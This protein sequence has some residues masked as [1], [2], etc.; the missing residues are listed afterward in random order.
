MKLERVGL[1]DCHSW[2]RALQSYEG[3]CGT[4]TREPIN[5][6]GCD[7]WGRIPI[8]RWQVIAIWDA[9]SIGREGPT[10]RWHQ[11]LNHETFRLDVRSYKFREGFFRRHWLTRFGF[12]SGGIADSSPTLEI[13][14]FGSS[15]TRTIADTFLGIDALLRGEWSLADKPIEFPLWDA[16][17]TRRGRLLSTLM[18]Q[19]M[20]PANAKNEGCTQD[21]L[22]AARLKRPAPST[23]I[24]RGLPEAKGQKRT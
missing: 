10:S 16:R 5:D 22:K 14:N 6:L 2:G 18:T 24:T 21:E 23:S 15:L 7:V 11:I 8:A 17:P 1:D 12:L 13:A 3:A 19:G 9:G 20:W 4:G